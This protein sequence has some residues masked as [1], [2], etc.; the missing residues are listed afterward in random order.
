MRKVAIRGLLARKAAPRPDGLRR[1]ARRDADR[2]HLRLHRHDQHSRSTRSS[3]QSNKGTDVASRPTTISVGDDGLRRRSPAR[4]CDKVQQVDG[5]AQAEGSVFER[6][7]LVPQG[8]RLQAQAA[9]RASSRRSARTTSSASRP[10]RR[11]RA[12]SRRPP[13]RSRSTRRRPTSSDFKLGDKRR[14]SADEARARS[15]THR[16]AS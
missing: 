9:H 14:R 10:S 8:R 12:I 3:S 2:R 11:P 1:R 7:R 13:T 15:Y 6:R 5:V 4:S 16:R